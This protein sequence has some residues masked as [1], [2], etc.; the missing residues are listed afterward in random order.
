M[1]NH[2]IELDTSSFNSQVYMGTKPSWV[3]FGAK[4]CPPCKAFGP[5]H[6]SVA[7]QFADQVLSCHVDIDDQPMLT[8]QHDIRSVPTHILFKDG[9]EVK[10][11]QG[12]LVR[13]AVETAYIDLIG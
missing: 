10:R 6:E 13:S 2:V 12:A 3:T 1:K 8:S 11:M 5:T 7:Q 4:W 9:V